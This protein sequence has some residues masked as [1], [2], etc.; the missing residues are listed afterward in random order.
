MSGDEINRI[1]DQD[2]GDSSLPRRSVYELF[3]KFKMTGQAYRTKK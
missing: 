1:H 3:E 2:Y